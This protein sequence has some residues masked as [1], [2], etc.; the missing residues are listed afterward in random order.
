MLNKRNIHKSTEEHIIKISEEFKKGLEFIKKYPRSI[1]FF[2]SSQLASDSEYYLKAKELA[3]KIVKDTDYSIVTG[4]GPGIMEAANSGAK[5]ALGKSVGINILLPERQKANGFTTDNINLDYFFVRKTILTFAAEAY[6]FFPG[7]L[8]T[9]DELFEILTLVQ[10]K[11]IEP[12]PIILFGSDF[13]NPVENLMTTLMK[14]KYNTID[15]ADLKLFTIT[16]SM[17]DVVEIIKKAPVE[18]Y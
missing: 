17:D 10:T 2:G 7:G 6:I 18:I 14:D 8:G 16:D 3:Y 9:F 15:D 12:V 13:W 1:T 5:D 11:K 4:G